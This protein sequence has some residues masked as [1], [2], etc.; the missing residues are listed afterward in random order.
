MNT[1]CIIDYT[2]KYFN[3][4]YQVKIYN[5]PNEYIHLRLLYNSNYYVISSFK[6]HN[7]LNEGI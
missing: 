6:V 5:Y 2:I 3:L 7:H 1:R 4:I